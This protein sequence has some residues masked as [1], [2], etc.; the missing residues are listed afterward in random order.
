MCAGIVPAGAMQALLDLGLTIPPSL[1][2]GEIDAYA[3]HTPSGSLRVSLSND[4]QARA[5]AIFRGN[6]PGPGLP[7]T[8]MSFDGWL[9]AEAQ[10]RGARVIRQH[11]EEACVQP[12]RWVRTRDQMWPCDLIVLASGINGH[13]VPIRGLPY[14]PPPT[15]LMAQG[16]MFLGGAEVARRLGS[17]VHVF[18]PRSLPLVFGA[19][20]PKGPFVSLSLLGRARANPSIR[21]FLNLEAVRRIL[22]Q[23]NQVCGCRPRIAVGPARCLFAEGFVA[24]GDAGVTRL[25]KNGLGTALVTAKKA[26][27]TVC[28]RGIGE[29]D[30]REQYAPLCQQIHRDNRFGRVLFRLVP[31][32][33]RSPFFASCRAL[34]A[35][36]EGERPPHEQMTRRALWGLLTGSDPYEEIFRMLLYAGLERGLSAA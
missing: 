28:L 3:L 36:R 4:P 27:E 32:L 30:L 7:V 23:A 26:A 17:A 16:E 22:P 12:S 20:V 10:R 29:R 6:G 33:M 18:F 11:V 5:V 21:E 24:V 2:M 15:E 9:L 34:L 31:L 35:D 14:L 19:L 25:Y 8:P 13:P 1:V